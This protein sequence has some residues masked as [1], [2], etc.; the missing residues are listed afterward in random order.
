MRLFTGQGV[1]VEDENEAA[2]QNRA[3][4]VTEWGPYETRDTIPGVTQE[5]Q[6]L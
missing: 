1:G 4:T 3:L 5:R 6:G 2:Q